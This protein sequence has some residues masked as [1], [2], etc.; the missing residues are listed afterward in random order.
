MVTTYFDVGPFRK[1]R[2]QTLPDQ[3]AQGTQGEDSHDHPEDTD[4]VGEQRLLCREEGKDKE[5]VREGYLGDCARAKS[6]DD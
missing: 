2:S 1:L 6:G 3:H 4:I 5:D